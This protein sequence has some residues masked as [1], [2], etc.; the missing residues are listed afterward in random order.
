LFIVIS[1][2][3]ALKPE[4]SISNS[5]LLFT[6]FE[7]DNRIAPGFRYFVRYIG[8]DEYLFDG[9]ARRL[10]SIGMGYGRRLTFNGDTLNFNENYFWTDSNSQGYA[11]SIE[12]VHEGDEFSIID[13][14]HQPVGTAVIE[15]AD[16]PQVELN[17]TVKDGKVV[18]DVKVR[19]SCF[20]K[21]NNVNTGVGS[22][23][24][25]NAQDFEMVEGTAQIVKERGSRKATV[26]C[27]K[28]V[29]F[30]SFGRCSLHNDS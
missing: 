14:N 5:S 19:F 16:F 26:R 2:K 9:E 1:Y 7:V 29:Y 24:N 13:S 10:E 15:T 25:V 23:I 28:D 3:H 27:V 30:Q 12:A 22:L 21:H 11:F 4:S 18:K 6:G 17:T 8:T 20:I